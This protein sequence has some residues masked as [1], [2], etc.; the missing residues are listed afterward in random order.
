MPT[1][2]ATVDVAGNKLLSAAHGRA[3]S[4]PI[5]FSTTGTLPAGLGSGVWY[6]RNPGTND[7]QVSRSRTGGEIATLADDGVGALLVFD[8]PLPPAVVMH[9]D[10]KDA[11]ASWGMAEVVDFGTKALTKQINQALRGRAG[12]VVVIPG[13]EQG[14]L[15]KLGPLRDLQQG[16]IF[17][18]G[19]LSEVHVWARDAN[20][21]PNDFR[22][23]YSAAW[24]LFELT[25]RA[26]RGSR[27]GRV[28]LGDVRRTIAP[29]ESVFGVEIVLPV[30][31]DG[32]VLES[33][34]AAVSPTTPEFSSAMV[35][36]SGDYV[37]PP[38]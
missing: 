3:E 27:V 22:A 30:T 10:I 35:F 32:L 33:A 7:F 17:S 23:H 24:D 13:D 5:R 18:F 26:I 38:S 1:T 28:M 31:L 25:L 14:K 6:V 4:A 12:R 9:D 21:D 20:A 37:T 19:E 8:A 34:G 16:A 15:G 36:P 29:V 2:I 11:F